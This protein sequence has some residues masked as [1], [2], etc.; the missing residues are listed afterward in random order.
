M[1]TKDTNWDDMLSIVKV[2]Q[3]ENYEL[4]SDWTKYNKDEYKYLKQNIG[5]ACFG[6]PTE[7]KNSDGVKETGNVLYIESKDN[8]NCNVTDALSYTQEAQKVIDE[9][10]SKVYEFG[11]GR[12][13]DDSIYYGIIFNV[14]FRVKCSSLQK[15]EEI[16][17]RQTPVFKIKRFKNVTKRENVCQ[18]EL[19]FYETWFIDMFGRVYKSWTDYKQYNT[20]PKCTMVLP[21]DGF[22]QPDE[23][24]EISEEY[25][26]VWLE[27]V[28][29]PACSTVAKVFQATDVASAVIGIAGVGVGVASMLTP[30]GP[31]ILG[32]TTI[33]GGSSA[34]W[35]FGRSVQHLVDRRNHKE[36][37]NPTHD[38]NAF[39]SWL[40]ITG[41]V[42]GVAAHGGTA[43][44]SRTVRNGGHVSRTAQVALNSVILSNVGINGI[45]IAHMAYCMYEKYQ[46]G[47][48][49]SSYDACVLT[50]HI[51]F[52][53]NAVINLQL[54]TE[55]IKSTKGTIL[56]EQ[57]AKV[58]AKNLKK[59]ANPEAKRNAA[60][61]NIETEQD[62]PERLQYLTKKA[63]V[64][65]IHKRGNIVIPM[66]MT[67]ENGKTRVDNKPLLDP[68]DFVLTSLKK[69]RRKMTAYKNLE[70][71]ESEEN[72]FNLF[73]V[74]RDLTLIKLTNFYSNNGNRNAIAPDID[75]FNDIFMDMKFLQNATN[76][77]SLIFE[78]ATMLTEQVESVSDCLLEAVYFIWYYVKENLKKIFSIGSY[79]VN[80]EQ[81]QKIIHSFVMVLSANL[82]RLVKELT[83]T[84]KYYLCK[85]S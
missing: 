4:L 25:S 71:S 11:N 74:L 54:A 78:G 81:S 53:A 28:D 56:D 76:M 13:D 43:L 60:A 7:C 55:L 14:T 67:F 30:I 57:R 19:D 40:A 72:D 38:R 66:V 68:M 58:R 34:A 32:A 80:D 39:C 16:C 9:I 45:G 52:F 29:S 22:Y 46:N 5:Y 77:L 73:F 69:P 50:A 70:I 47:E 36:S 3:Q 44:L 51:L 49:V 41:S 62:I 59:R 84:F 61:N 83:P 42:A 1:A 31:I 26:Q 64:Q 24:Y 75:E 33:A 65:H 23:E 12:V 21:K 85:N 15:K 20:L 48:G 2:Q 35:S 63:D 10:Y 8:S 37:I 17:V 82:N 79:S 6:P 27:I 18:K